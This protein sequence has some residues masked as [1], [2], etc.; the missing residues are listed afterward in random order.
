MQHGS[1]E[2]STST[3]KR[4][5]KYAI[6]SLGI[7]VFRIG[8]GIATGQVGREDY[9]D[10]IGMTVVTFVLFLAVFSIFRNNDP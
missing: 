5:I 10:A 3:L 2:H 1:P 4:I 6:V 8:R 7:G 9:I